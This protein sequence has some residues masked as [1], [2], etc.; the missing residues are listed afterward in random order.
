MGVLISSLRITVGRR[1]LFTIA[2]SGH[3]NSQVRLSWLFGSDY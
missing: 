3:E 2:Q 1:N